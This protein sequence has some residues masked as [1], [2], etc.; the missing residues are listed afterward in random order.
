M[1]SR[2]FCLLIGLF[3]AGKVSGQ[4]TFLQSGPMVGYS[5][6]REALIW[7]QTNAPA[8]V[9]FEYWDIKQPQIRF[10]TDNYNTNKTEA[11]TA[12]LIADQL[13]P[14]HQ[15]GYELFINNKKV[16]R[17]YPLTFQSQ[18]L[19]EY[20]TDPPPFRFAFGS[21]TY[22]NDEPFDRPGRSYGSDYLIFNSIYQQKPDFMLWGG[23]NLYLREGDFDSR[24]GIMYRNTHTRSTKEL[25]PLLGSVHHYATWDD[26][27]FG[28]NDADGS[29]GLKETTTEA[30]RLFWGNQSYGSGTGGKGISSS[31]KW[32]DVEFFLL[33]DRYFRTANENHAQPR[34]ML[35]KE[36]LDWLINALAVSDAAFKFV[37]IGCQ[38]LNPAVVYENYSTYAEER[39]ELIR[40]IR[41]AGIK[42]VL[43]LSGDRHHTELTKLQ[44]R[45]NLYPLYDLTCSPL[46]SGVSQAGNSEPNTLRVPNT[47][48]QE[49]NFALM[50]VSGPRKERKLKISIMSREGKLLWDKEIAAKELE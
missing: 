26:H 17:D 42:R 46:T 6:K 41:A 14:G 38:V 49:H 36:Q 5:A 19:W 28:P 30:F 8:T 16:S 44:E 21:C 31:F 43:F 50:E 34:Q 24:T 47:L 35:G 1:Y 20:R 13:A 23:D 4:G 10:R 29:Y 22:I 32:S 15:Y 40:L 7:V 25:Q 12:R 39:A 3:I 48:V 45:Q 33:D 2:F 9:H 11:F 18:A 37:V 27:E